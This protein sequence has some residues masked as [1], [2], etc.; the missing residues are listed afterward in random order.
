MLTT[1]YDKAWKVMKQARRGEAEFDE[2]LRAAVDFV[3]DECARVAERTKLHLSNP[4]AINT[5]QSIE[6][7]IHRLKAT[8][9]SGGGLT[10]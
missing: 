7:S 3:I 1:V 5:A 8:Q 9:S 6:D 4:T 2:A 10:K